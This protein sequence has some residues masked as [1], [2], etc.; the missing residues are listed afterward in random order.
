MKALYSLLWRWH[1]LIGLL[2]AP[3]LISVSLSG[4]LYVFEPQLE[5]LLESYQKY[6]ACA[7]CARLSYSQLADAAQQQ[8][9]DWLVHVLYEPFHGRAVQVHLEDPAGKQP[10]LEVFLDPH[11]GNIIHTRN[12]GDGIFPFILRLHR[13]LL[14]GEIGRHITELMISWIFVTLILGFLLWWPRRSKGGGGWWP[15]MRSKGRRFWRDLHS[16][17][18]FYMLPLFVLIAFTGLFFSP[19]A[20][21]TIL[22]G[23]YVADQLPEIY[24]KPPKVSEPPLQADRLPID[25][26]ISDFLARNDVDYFDIHF[27]EEPEDAYVISAHVGFDVWKIRQSHYNPY[28]GE[29]LGEARWDDLKP[30]AKA[31]LLFFPLHTGSIFGLG[32]QIIA[33]IAALLMVGISITGIVMWSIRRKPGELGMPELNANQQGLGWKGWTLVIVLGLL[34]PAFGASLLAIFIYGGLRWLWQRRSAGTPVQEGA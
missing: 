21:K 16:V 26:M 28:T 15:R 23:M 1:F 13:T 34:W 27:A 12:E 8:R 9:P 5:P 22:A 30:G 2:A 6:P 33:L 25:G 31:M 7:D 17:V 10:D 32:T 14:S 18:G 3:I 20:N 4:A 19:W 24:L 29:L 11:N